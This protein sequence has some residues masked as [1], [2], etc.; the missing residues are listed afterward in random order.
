MLAGGDADVYLCGP[1]AM[2]EATRTWL[3]NNSFHRVGLYYEKFVASG[4]ARRRA[5][6]RLDYAN[7]DIADVRRRG[8]GTA[9]VIGGSIAGIA[10]AKVMQRDLR[11]ASSCS[12][13]T[14]RTGGGR[15]A[16][17]PHRA[18]TCITC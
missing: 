7:V 9:V 12:R 6:A 15:A 13:R 11:T 16:P 2:V 18:G 4:A 5:P 10:A 8:R 3:E 14:T 17:V 1:A